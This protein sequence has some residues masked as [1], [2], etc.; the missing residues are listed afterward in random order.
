MYGEVRELSELS[1]AVYKTDLLDRNKT[2]SCRFVVVGFVCLFH[3][4]VNGKND[5]DNDLHVVN[6][7]IKDISL[8]GNLCETEFLREALW[9]LI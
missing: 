3:R 9:F 7:G 1:E 2:W 4:M 8:C 6:S 5:L